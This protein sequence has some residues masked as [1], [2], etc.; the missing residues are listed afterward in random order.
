MHVEIKTNI[1]TKQQ[2]QTAQDVLSNCVHC[3]FCNAT[4][5]TYRIIGDERDGPRG[6]IY[7]IK[8][9]LEGNKSSPQSLQHLDQCLTCKSCETHCPS[10]VK[11]GSLVEIG[12]EVA[13]KT[14]QRKWLDKTK[15][16][17][18][19]KLLLNR[20][21]F[22]S[23]LGLG[24]LVK[25]VL[26]KQLKHQVPDKH[27]GFEVTPTISER[28]VLL[29]EGCLQPAIQ[30]SINQAAIKI[31]NQLGIQ[32]VSAQEVCCGAISQHNQAEDEALELMKTN[33]DYWWCNIEQGVEAII[34]TASGCGL[35]I[36]D[37]AKYLQNDEEYKK[38]AEKIS[39]LTKDVI[40]YLLEQELSALKLKQD[41]AIISIQ[42]P[43]TLQHGQGLPEALETLM[44]KLGYETVD[45]SDKYLC[46]GSAGTYSLFQA[47]LA[48]KLRT[49]KLNTLQQDKADV[50]VTANIGCLH[51][52]EA[53]SKI[54]VRHCLELLAKDI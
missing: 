22:S 44:Q 8:S 1:I 25:P 48:D 49:Q 47:K 17:L 36:K 35:Q 50:I 16:V 20:T 7:L 38:K 19:R 43:C 54:P 29:L 12:K 42:T 51:H 46:C 10:G 37:Y 11:Y 24:R 4:C 53:A 3:G 39:E 21:L 27:Q 31:F 15:R 33:I 26:P 5:P 32:T 28:K 40:E 14:I 23:A 30:S 6:R 34:S 45:V 52:L 2:A 9:L 13:E 41:K 18:I